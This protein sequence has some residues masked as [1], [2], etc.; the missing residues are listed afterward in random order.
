MDLQNGPTMKAKYPEGWE[1]PE[2]ERSLYCHCGHIGKVHKADT[3]GR[4]LCVGICSD[5]PAYELCDCEEWKPRA[6]V[7]SS[8][9]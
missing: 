2:V 6:V 8:N 3:E 9:L 4:M 1:P 5:K 7:V